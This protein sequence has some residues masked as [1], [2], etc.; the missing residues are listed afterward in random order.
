LKGFSD[1]VVPAVA[2]PEQKIAGI[3]DWMAN[4]PAR[5]PDGPSTVT[6]NRDPTDTLNYKSL[7]K[8]CGSATNAFINLADSSGLTARRLL[9][10]DSRG[11]AKHVVAEVRLNGE[12]IVVDPSFRTM[13][14]GDRGQYLTSHDLADPEVFAIAIRNIRDYDTSYTY[15][16]T[17]HVRMERIPILGRLARKTFNHILPGWEDSPTL[18]LFL[19]RNSFA[20]LVASLLL[21]VFS[22]LLR[23]CLRWVGESR[24]GVRAV[25]IRER[26]RRAARALLTS[27]T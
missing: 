15:G 24:F 17:E 16:E 10:L 12:W 7:L 9:L 5:S 1:A 4:G 19:E 27:T 8:V 23:I 20:A 18:S 2:T 11:G 14:R 26:I 13:L 25:H 21:L 6:E 3:L 22:A